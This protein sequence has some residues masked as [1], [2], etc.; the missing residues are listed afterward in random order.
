MK[1]RS[2]FV[3]NSSSASFIVHLK[4]PNDQLFGF[5]NSNIEPHFC[6]Y[7]LME[8]LK[9]SLA[10]FEKIDAENKEEEAK[11]K[12]KNETLKFFRT[13]W[14]HLITKIKKQ[15]EDLERLYK[16]IHE[17]QDPFKKEK[18]GIEYVKIAGEVNH[19][20]ISPL[21]EGEDN[22]CWVLTSHTSMYNDLNDIPEAMRDVIVACNFYGIKI[23][24]E[25]DESN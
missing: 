15:I 4:M 9:K 25:I 19:I 7:D 13:D 1:I 14:G 5:F 16:E 12:E 6:N 10:H 2:S 17:E 3:S 8:K 24:C 23:K 22:D 11:A 18:L 21:F 20:Y